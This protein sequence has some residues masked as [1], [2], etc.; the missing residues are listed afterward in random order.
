MIISRPSHG[1]GYLFSDNRAAGEG[2]QEDDVFA[3]NH[4]QK[5]V[6]KSV[7]AER[8]GMC[9]QCNQIICIECYGFLLKPL[10]EGG[11]CRPF[12][13]FLEAQLEELY[14]RDQNAKLLGI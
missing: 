3:C 10:D 5:L 13:Q 7:I 2:L 9:G 8:G 11:G 14:R 4:C 1:A 12:L 6:L